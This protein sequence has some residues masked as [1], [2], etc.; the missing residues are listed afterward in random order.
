MI[1]QKQLFLWIDQAEKHAANLPVPQRV[2]AIADEVR[3]EILREGSCEWISGEI[4]S[5]VP[6]EIVAAYID[7]SL[8]PQTT[9]SLSQQIARDRNLLVEVILTRR[10]VTSD[11]RK[12]SSPEKTTLPSELTDRLLRLAAPSSTT[13]QASIPPPVHMPTRDE[14]NQVPSRRP[15]WIAIS[16]IAALLMLALAL[17]WLREINPTPSDDPHQPSLVQDDVQPK[18]PIGAGPPDASPNETVVQSPPM[19]PTP[20]ETPGPVDPI[21]PPK[22]PP[23]MPQ[24]NLALEPPSEPTVQP[25]DPTPPS[26]PD[27]LREKFPVKQPMHWIVKVDH[28]HGILL[29]QASHGAGRTANRSIGEKTTLRLGAVD[30]GTSTTMPYPTLR[31]L[32]LSRA[33]G[34][35]EGV[36]EYVLAADTRLHVTD[37]GGMDL[38]FGA[39]ALREMAEG[40]ELKIKQGNH[41]TTKLTVIEKTNFVMTRQN[42]GLKIEITRGEIRWREHRLTQGTHLV[43]SNED[44]IQTVD[45][46]LPKTPPWVRHSVDRISLPNS[47]LAQIVSTDDFS[48][49][50]RNQL[51]Q[52]SQRP[53][54]RK[55]QT[56]RAILASWLVSASDSQLYRF[57]GVDDPMIRYAALD[58]MASIV[59]QDPRHRLVWRAVR[60]G[61][62]NKDVYQQV[63]NLFLLLGRGQRPSPD[64][65]QALLRML[66]TP[67]VQSKVT[68]DYL[69]RRFY[70]KGPNFN[71]GMNRQAT[72][73]VVTAWQKIIRQSSP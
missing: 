14:E 50:V 13:A 31:T 70:G 23:K 73:R 60:S 61:V 72:S 2:D 7:Q 56:Q 51:K 9:R 17:Q 10:G 4:A 64:Q 40:S 39:M 62:K 35:I 15:W 48:G 65:Q 52:F 6:F 63:Y 55:N 32:P 47:I 57:L 37:G 44:S 5:V 26:A 67:G 22:T 34:T 41:P 11:H 59:P 12:A 58:R 69:L 24:E 54:S 8:D 21:S 30:S 68:A 25:D 46:S 19:P 29:Q 33:D 3:G 16:A 1:D 71:P 53:V 42:D 38:V 49:S 28:V 66:Q 45:T 36:G 18:Q 43:R 20:P 27:L